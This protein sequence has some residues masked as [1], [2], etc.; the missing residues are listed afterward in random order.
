M[1]RG[2]LLP[3]A[4]KAVQPFQK[5][6]LTVLRYE[7]AFSMDFAPPDTLLVSLKWRGSMPDG[8]GQV[9]QGRA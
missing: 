4:D 3:A 8:R 6:R 7:R 5:D 2:V 1:K 9:F